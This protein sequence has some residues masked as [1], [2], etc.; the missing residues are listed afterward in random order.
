M[1]DRSLCDELAFKR[2]PPKI[3][4]TN[5]EKNFTISCPVLKLAKIKEYF[6]N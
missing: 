4:P 6:I 3:P 5:L 2:T 1:I